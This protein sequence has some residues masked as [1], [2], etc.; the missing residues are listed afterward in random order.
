MLKA[1]LIASTAMVPMASVSVAQAQTGARLQ[2]ASFDIPAQS[3][4]DSLAAFARVTGLRIA[5]PAELAQGRSAPALQGPLTQ[6]QA[7]ERLLSG[8]GLAW[9]FTGGNA[10][11]V[12]DPSTAVA[13]AP[14]NADGSLVLDTITISG[15]GGGTLGSHDD[16]YGSTGSVSYISGQEIE[17]RRGTSAGD[18]ISGIP[19]V[20]NGDSRNSGA[21]DVN[22]RGLQGQGRVPVVIDGATQEQTVYRG[23][24]GARSGSYVD[25]DFI[26]EVSVEKGPSAAADGSGAIGGVVRMRTLSAADI[27]L[28]G[29]QMGVRLR[30]GFNTNSTTPPDVLTPGGM[31]GGSYAA[32]STPTTRDGGNMDRPAFLDPTGGNGSVAAALSSESI[33]LVA[34]YARRHN[35]N[36]FSGT[37]GGG[38]PYFVDRT[39]D[40]DFP[41]IGYEGLSPWKGG[42]E[43]LNTSTDT[44]SLLLK[45]NIRFGTDHALELSYMRYDSEFGEIMP[46]RLGTHTSAVGGY[47]SEP[48]TLDLKTWN[49]RYRWSPESDLINL[50]VNAFRTDLD[51]RATNLLTIGNT[52]TR[53]VMYSQ[54]IRDGVSVS[55]ESVIAPIPG[56]FLLEYGGAWQRET[57]G[58]PKDLEDKQWVINHSEFPPRSGSRTET[59]AFANGKWDIA[60]EWQVA[61]GLRYVDFRTMDRNYSF[62][63]TGNWPD[64]AYEMIPGQITHVSSSG[65][66]KNLSLSWRPLDDLHLYGRYSDALRMPSIFETLKGFSTAYLPPDLRPERAK[67]FEFGANKT[68]EV[69]TAE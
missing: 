38:Q 66:S 67:V 18:F 47:Q 2:P 60:P 27:L 15:A 35:G 14:V 57:V 21:L 55:N 40:P 45:S 64:F 34:A 4:S 52:T 5:Y 28:P 69:S 49:A 39:T 42:E 3:L 9:R 16:T 19:G 59:S 8:S 65:L 6:T 22:I 31:A 24:N 46:T 56:E 36:Y 68:F 20:I 25:P 13:D 53:S 12:Y 48:D 63:M 26:G 30:G 62:N 11:T 7:L 54:T 58:L 17:Q 29:K 32:G 51:H 23:Y 41:N 33:D 43:V 10:V 50:K 37:K 1:F 44:E 61:A